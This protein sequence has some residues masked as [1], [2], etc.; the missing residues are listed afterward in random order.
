MG[1]G[2]FL[3]SLRSF[4]KYLTIGTLSLILE[5]TIRIYFIPHYPMG[6]LLV[7]IFFY[8]LYEVLSTPW[9]KYK[10]KDKSTPKI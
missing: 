8:T 7:L 4:F 9:K 1:Q 3:G 2:N 6:L 5:E 10:L